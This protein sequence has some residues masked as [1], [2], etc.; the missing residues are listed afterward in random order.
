MCLLFHYATSSPRLPVFVPAWNC[1]HSSS[2]KNGHI[3]NFKSIPLDHVAVSLYFCLPCSG[4]VPLVFVSSMEPLHFWGCAGLVGWL[5]SQGEV[6]CLSTW[7]SIA[8]GGWVWLL[9]YGGN[10]Y[11][12]C[13]SR[14]AFCVFLTD[15]YMI[16]SSSD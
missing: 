14:E 3:L 7:I 15:Q 4:T 9:E 11:L 10:E 5:S 2:S 6:T 1:T 8:L 12:A 16:Q 13:H